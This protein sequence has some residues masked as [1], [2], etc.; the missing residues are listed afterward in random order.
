MRVLIIVKALNALVQKHLILE[1]CKDNFFSKVPI[2]PKPL[3][4][5]KTECLRGY[6]KEK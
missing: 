4:K 3:L 1:H 2:A 5:C 6:L